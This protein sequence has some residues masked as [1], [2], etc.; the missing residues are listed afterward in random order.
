MTA[1]KDN[2]RIAAEWASKAENDLRNA[3]HTLKLGAAGP[4]DTICFHA[5]QCVE[6]YLKAMLA[7]GGI[8]FARTH[9]IEEL[10]KLL[11]TSLNLKL[12]PSEQAILTDYAT[13][14]RYPGD[15]EPISLT[16][17]KAAV[18][19]ARRVRKQIRKLLPNEALKPIKGK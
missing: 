4:I 15:Y 13:T 7:S 6:K 12:S 8:E 5:Q 1:G 9:D 17:A 3:A 10:V 19:M 14:T 2:L 11:P 18:A 16:E